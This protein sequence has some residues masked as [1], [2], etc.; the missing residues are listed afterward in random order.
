MMGQEVCLKGLL[1]PKDWY[2]NGRVKSVV[3]ATDDEQEICI[4]NPLPKQLIHHLRERVA[5]WGT[6]EEADNQT[7]F[8][9]NRLQ[10]GRPAPE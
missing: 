2:H 3:L 4:R 9:V 6:F 5:L 8:Q 10:F 1:I 7:A